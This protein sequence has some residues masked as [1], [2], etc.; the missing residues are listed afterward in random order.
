[1]RVR[2]V[3]RTGIGLGSDRR[4]DPGTVLV[5]EL[6]PEEEGPRRSV[7]ARVVHATPQM[8]GTF[9]VGCIFLEP[10]SDADLR[11]LTQ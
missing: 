9:L 1:V 10:L 6:P 2:N 11:L 7:R 4:W 8:G 3:S 5:V